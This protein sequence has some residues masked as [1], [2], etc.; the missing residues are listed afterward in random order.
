MELSSAL[1][2]IQTDFQAV[3]QMSHCLHRLQSLDVSH[4]SSDWNPWQLYS[5]YLYIYI[6]F[7]WSCMIVFASVCTNECVVCVR[8]REWEEDGENWIPAVLNKKTEAFLSVQFYYWSVSSCVALCCHLSCCFAYQSTEYICGAKGTVILVCIF[9][10]P[11]CCRAL[12]MFVGQR[13]LSFWCVYLLLQDA[14]EHWICLWG[15]GNSH[16]GV[17]ICYYKMLQSTEYVR[18]AKGTVILVC[19]FV[20]TRCC[21]ALENVCL[22]HS[23]RSATTAAE[24]GTSSFVNFFQE[25]QVVHNALQKQTSCPHRKKPAVTTSR[26]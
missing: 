11:R 1:A 25:N 22:Q 20:I 5:L 16:S 21:R 17:Y 10:I 9:V 12:N 8:D 3:S 14:A 18:G 19:I 2:S 7:C 13:E 4:N 15:R 24:A 6:L 26:L 23:K